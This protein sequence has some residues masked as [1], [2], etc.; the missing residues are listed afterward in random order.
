MS[1]L[2]SRVQVSFLPFFIFL[3]MIEYKSLLVYFC[4]SWFLAVL[5][6]GLSILFITASSYSEKLSAYECGFDPFDDARNQFDVRFYLVAI[7]FLVFDLEASFLYPWV[8]SLGKISFFGFW[9]MVDFFLELLVG[10]FYAW[11]IGAL[12]WE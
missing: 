3:A 8:V 11:R 1:N 5:I 4:L 2:R 12:V 10:F 9:S 7:L 6:F